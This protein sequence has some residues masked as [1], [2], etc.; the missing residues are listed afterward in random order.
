MKHSV[1]VEM[2]NGRIEEAKRDWRGQK[3]HRDD[4]QFCAFSAIGMI[5]MC[6]SLGVL[7][8]DVARTLLDDAYDCMN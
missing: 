5:Q 1:A 3:P 4:V 6:V 8:D 2:I 7:D